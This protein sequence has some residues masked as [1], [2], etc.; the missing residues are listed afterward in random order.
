MNIDLRKK[1]VIDLKKYIGIDKQKAIV[2][3]CYDRSGSFTWAYQNGLMQRL[4]ERVLPIGLGFDDDG[5]VDLFI[6][7]NEAW[8]SKV[9]ITLSTINDVIPEIKKHPS[10]GTK[11]APAIKL[12]LDEY[13]G[14]AKSSGLFGLGKASRPAKTLKYPVFVLYFTDGDN[15]DKRE[16]EAILREASNYGIFFQFIGVGDA[17]MYFLEKVNGLS[18]TFID[19]CGFFRVSD[20]DNITDEQLYSQMMMEFPQFIIKARSKNLI[21]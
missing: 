13:I 10:G 19:N 3:C 5:V 11:Y 18:G 17:D 7:H 2:A 15:D 21:S 20:I 9:D 12:I 1:I 8:R 14:E 6:F 4:T 16:T